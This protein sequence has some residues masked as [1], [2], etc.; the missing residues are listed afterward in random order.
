MAGYN[1]DQRMLTHQEESRL[2]ELEKK[3]FGSGLTDREKSEFEVLAR[4]K[5]Q[6]RRA[7]R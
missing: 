2:A 1:P 4:L 6:L 7:S 3:A 5:V